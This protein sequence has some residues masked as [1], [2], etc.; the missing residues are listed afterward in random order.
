MENGTQMESKAIKEKKGFFGSRTPKEKKPR[1][2]LTK[3]R[4]IAYIAVGI[5]ALYFVSTTVVSAVK[6]P[7][8]KMVTFGG[9]EKGEFIQTLATNGTLRSGAKQTVYAPVNGTIE[10]VLVKEGQVVSAEDILLTYDAEDLARTLEAKEAG[11]Y[12]TYYGNKDKLDKDVNAQ[13]YYDMYDAQVKELQS[14]IDVIQSVIDD[15]NE[16]IARLTADNAIYT[17]RGESSDLV[18]S[19]NVDIASLQKYIL[20]EQNK[21]DAIKPELERKQKERDL[22]EKNNLTDNERKSIELGMKSGR[23]DLEAL[24]DSTQLAKNGVAAEMAGVV[25]GLSAQAGESIAQGKPIATIQSM[26]SVEVGIQLSKYDLEKVKVGQKA[27]VTILGNQY[28]ATVTAIDQMAT[29]ATGSTTA[30]VN[31]TVRLSNP[32]DKIYQPCFAA[33]LKW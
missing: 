32:D 8:P 14:K 3:K 7:A 30:Y 24:K 6:G 33:I 1:K 11:F 26:D 25:T 2:K 29:V 23:L 19:N 28:D 10:N 12:S 15:Y 9:A 13:Q 5:I 27:Q 31:A 20:D 16:Q 22:N 18:K 4:L 17:T 21:I